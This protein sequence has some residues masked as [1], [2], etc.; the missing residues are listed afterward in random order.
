MLFVDD[1]T[2]QNGPKYCAHVLFCV[3]TYRKT[4]TCLV[5]KI[6]ILGKFFQAWVIVLLALGSVLMNQ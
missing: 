4:V 6:Q 1:F 5:E 2:V 3:P